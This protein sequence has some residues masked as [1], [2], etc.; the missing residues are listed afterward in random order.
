MSMWASLFVPQVAIE[1]QDS[2]EAK[3]RYEQE[4]TVVHAALVELGVSV[5]GDFTDAKTVVKL[6]RLCGRSGQSFEHMLQ[7]LSSLCNDAPLL[8]DR[9]RTGAAHVGKLPRVGNHGAFT[10]ADDIDTDDA[11]DDEPGDNE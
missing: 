11:S 6:N 4:V 9:L 7:G 3:R 10:V 8:V 5:P 1:R 2:D